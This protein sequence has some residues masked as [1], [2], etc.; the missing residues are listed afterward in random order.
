VGHYATYRKRGAHTDTPS[1]LPVP[2]TPTFGLQDD[3]LISEQPSFPDPNGTVRLF[4]C[5]TEFGAYV[6][7]D[8]RAAQALINWTDLQATE[9][10]WYKVDQQGGGTNFAG[11]S[12]LSAAFEYEEP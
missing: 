5:E 9:S 8:Q 6:L 10:G 3:D 1:A 12:P 7:S 11:T 4:F 2:E